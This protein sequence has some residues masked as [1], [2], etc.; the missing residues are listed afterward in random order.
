MA[1]TEMPPMDMTVAVQ[2]LVNL[3]L[4]MDGKSRE[5]FI[6]LLVVKMEEE[7][8]DLILEVVD[9]RNN[10]NNDFNGLNVKKDDV[11]VE[12]DH[13]DSDSKYAHNSKT[14]TNNDNNTEDKKIDFYNEGSLFA[15]KEE[16][17]I[18]NQIPSYKEEKVKKSFLC[19][20]CPHASS[21]QSHLKE[22]KLRY[23]TENGEE[24]ILK[25]FICEI[26]SK[27]FRTNNNLKMHT[28]RQHTKNNLFS[29]DQCSYETT[30]ITSMKNHKR[31]H[32]GERPYVC[33]ICSKTFTQIAHL[34]RHIKGIHLGEKVNH[35]RATATGEKKYLCDL[36]SAAFA[37][38]Q[39]LSEHKESIHEGIK[40]HCDQCGH[41]A[42]TRRNLKNHVAAVHE[43]ITFDCRECDYKVFSK[44]SLRIHEESVHLGIRHECNQCDHKATC[45][46]GLNQ[47]IAN[48]HEYIQRD[49]KECNFTTYKKRAFLKHMTGHRKAQ[50]LQNQTDHNEE[51]YS[52]MH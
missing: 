36:C 2:G 3:F 1:A 47:H 17:G 22:H 41:E 45:K 48:V 7:E 43:G 30:H 13:F 39:S 34:N 4:N 6:K 51:D 10:S 14:E 9:I 24:D 16:V 26:C 18:D 32:T 46:I 49:C 50:E 40:F 8:V 25:M 27:S 11:K 33:H 21:R 42:A 29:C 19:D 15:M 20:Q 35:Y 44:Q 28:H 5:M 38:Q 37:S 23:H 12:A 31:S 52:T